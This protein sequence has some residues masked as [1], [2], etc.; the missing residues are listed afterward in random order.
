MRVVEMYN[1]WP[2][3]VTLEQNEEVKRIAMFNGPK[4]GTSVCSDGM[5]IA[6]V[7]IGPK[8]E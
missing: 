3:V 6:R 1:E 8:E 2:V 5:S 7:Y 4:T